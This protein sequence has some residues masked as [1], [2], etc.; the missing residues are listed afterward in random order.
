MFCLQASRIF[1][2]FL[3]R[4]L[5]PMPRLRSYAGLAI[6]LANDLQTHCKA[7]WGKD[8]VDIWHRQAFR[9]SRCNACGQKRPG[10]LLSGATPTPPIEEL[11]EE[12]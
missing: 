2:A 6:P 1:E 7:E 11:N 10:L 4:V 3:H 12:H 9:S 8:V 5:S